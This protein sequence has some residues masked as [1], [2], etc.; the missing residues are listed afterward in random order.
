MYDNLSTAIGALGKGWSTNFDYTL[1]VDHARAYF[2]LPNGE[3]VPFAFD[4]ETGAF[5]PGSEWQTGYTL[6]Y[7]DSLNRTTRGLTMPESVE[8][9]PADGYML[10]A[11]FHIN[12]PENLEDLEDLEDLENL[13]NLE[14]PEITS[15]S[16]L[17]TS[18]SALDVVEDNIEPL[19]L[20]SARMSNNDGVSLAAD[21][22]NEEPFSDSNEMIPVDEPVE[23]SFTTDDG[24]EIVMSVEK[25]PYGNS[26]QPI[27]RS[28]RVNSASAAPSSLFN[29]VDK[30]FI[31]E[32]K[33]GT[34]YF[35]NTDQKITSIEQNG[36]T[37]YTYLY[38]G[39]GQVR[40]VEGRYGAGFN[41]SY[42]DGGKLQ[43]VTDSAGAIVTFGY[44][45]DLLVES[46]NPDGDNL[47]YSYDSLQN[48]TAVKDF[49][50]VV[51]ITNI[52]DVN[53]RAIRQT[54]ADRGIYTAV[55]DDLNW[56][57][58]FTD[59]EGRKQNII[60]TKMNLL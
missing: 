30:S 40:R 21:R 28:A 4:S 49:A 11:E 45:G 50:G 26:Q 24:T 35:F 23:H 9:G 41:L 7:I 54:V 18:P 47:T 25:V 43:S 6:S 46:V 42:N 1:E 39:A 10:R 22:T 16:D 5:A 19:R 44:A 59:P 20:R 8:S 34:K 29:P 31:V 52:F 58:T 12:N 55:Y 33:D 56:V 37:K 60:T 14:Q 51:Y 38:N 2:T 32:Y 13:E 17:S 48:L 36:V 57:N 53:N 3:G 15:D 27:M